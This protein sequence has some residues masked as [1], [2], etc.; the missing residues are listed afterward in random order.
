MRPSS[1]GRAWRHRRSW[2]V[3]WVLSPLPETRDSG[4]TPSEQQS[5]AAER[6]FCCCC[7]RG[8]AADPRCCPNLASCSKKAIKLP[9]LSFCCFH[10][11]KRGLH[12]AAPSSIATGIFPVCKAYSNV[13]ILPRS[14]NL[15]YLALSLQRLVHSFKP[16]GAATIVSSSE[17]Y[18]QHPTNID[19]A[20]VLVICRRFMRL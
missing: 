11:I 13:A 12:T 10:I 18:I 9:H 15:R 7:S 3:A 8:K 17:P 1:S 6:C 19:L 20:Q 2:G 16:W 14:L 4:R 5:G